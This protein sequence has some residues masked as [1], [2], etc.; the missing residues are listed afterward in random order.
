MRPNENFSA[1]NVAQGV[2]GGMHHT[3]M[4]HRKWILI[5]ALIL[6]FFLA[7]LIKILSKAHED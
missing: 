7:I 1:H 4:K 2:A 3:V 5:V 6:N